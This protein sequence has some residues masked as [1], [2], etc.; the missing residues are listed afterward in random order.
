MKKNLM[1]ALVF[2]SLASVTL[3]A[4]N[5]SK[6]MNETRKE[7]KEEKPADHLLIVWTSGD[8]DVAHKMVFM[9]AF[10]AKKNGWWKN[11]TLLVWG[12]SAKLSSEDKDIQAALLKMKDEGVEL[13][14]CKGC[15][16][17]YGVS[18]KLEELGIEV[19]YTGTYLTDFIKSGKKVIT[20]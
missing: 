19:K 17:Q 1:L 16:D 5:P 7:M 15:A 9:Y 4:A 8:P 11:V 14:A 3:N 12:P 13:L 18:P 20:F 2:F 6:T 10:N